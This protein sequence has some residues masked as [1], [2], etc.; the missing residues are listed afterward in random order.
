MVSKLVS[1]IIVSSLAGNSLNRRDLLVTPS[2][3]LSSNHVLLS[4]EQT[5]QKSQQDDEWK[6]TLPLERFF[7]GTN[8]IRV[9][10]NGQPQQTANNRIIRPKRIYKLI[11]DTGSPYLTIPFEKGSDKDDKNG[12]YYST[13]YEDVE[14]ANDDIVYSRDHDMLGFKSLFRL[15]QNTLSSFTT[16]DLDLEEIPFTVKNRAIYFAVLKQ[17]LKHSY[18]R[19]R[20]YPTPNPT[21]N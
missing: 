20:Y 7:G 19:D 2:I 10:L 9:S 17:K 15:L 18:I 13:I 16:L 5:T 14:P 1:Y 6:V 8:C 12:Y 21:L 11:V 3:L 4:P